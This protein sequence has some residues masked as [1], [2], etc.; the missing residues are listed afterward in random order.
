MFVDFWAA[1]GRTEAGGAFES[2]NIIEEFDDNAVAL[3]RRCIPNPDALMK[4]MMDISKTLPVYDDKET[5]VNKEAFSDLPA[6]V[7]ISYIAGNDNP[8]DNGWA[9]RA[10]S[11][12]KENS[13][14][15]ISI[16]KSFEMLTHGKM[17]PL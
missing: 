16:L 8:K 6:F 3:I 11:G 12:V 15:H 7:L 5:I 1:L 2:M 4:E 10:W 14:L 9:F 17:M 13:D